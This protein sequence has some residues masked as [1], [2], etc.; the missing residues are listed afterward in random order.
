MLWF[1]ITSRLFFY[2]K[3]CQPKTFQKF[4]LCFVTS[5]MLCSEHFTCTI[6]SFV[7]H[8]PNDLFPINTL[9][10][11]QVYPIVNIYEKKM[12]FSLLFVEF[13]IFFSLSENLF[14]LQS[15]IRFLEFYV[16]PSRIFLL[17]VILSF[18]III[19]THL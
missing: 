13:I 12:C 4:S 10:R 6:A 8:Y 15:S 9:I 16:Y 18:T 5:I 11:F 14:V 17:L 3:A 1:F 19:V 2:K 7:Q